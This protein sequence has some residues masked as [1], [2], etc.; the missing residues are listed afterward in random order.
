MLNCV[1]LNLTVVI[2]NAGKIMFN[3]KLWE[4]IK[5]AYCL[6]L[7]YNNKIFNFINFSM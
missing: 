5:Q 4:N 6:M 1:I 7:F 2:T 3:K